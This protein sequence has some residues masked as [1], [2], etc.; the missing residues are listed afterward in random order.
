VAAELEKRWAGRVLLD[1]LY[2]AEMRETV[3]AEIQARHANRAQIA[4][5][6][7]ISEYKLSLFLHGGE[8]R[9]KESEVVACWCEKSERQPPQVMPELVALG[10]LAR[11]APKSEVRAVRRDLARYLLSR[12]ERRLAPSTVDSLREV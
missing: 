6:I 8:L 9:E 12:F 3:R 7:G 11:W 4:E 10:V 5:E 2:L 1:E